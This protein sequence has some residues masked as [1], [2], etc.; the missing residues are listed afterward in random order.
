MMDLTY[1]KVVPVRDKIDQ[2][3]RGKIDPLTDKYYDEI[4]VG[5]RWQLTID[6][7]RYLMA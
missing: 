5:D 4:S 7:L 1:P 3:V 2:F 6:S